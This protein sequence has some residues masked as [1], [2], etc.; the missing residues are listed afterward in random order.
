MNWTTKECP[1]NTVVEHTTEV[2]NVVYTLY[3]D[4]AGFEGFIAINTFEIGLEFGAVDLES[5]TREDA[6]KEL[7]AALVTLAQGLP[8]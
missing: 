6:V 4:P 3:E 1:D 2:D 8:Q 7:V 5:K